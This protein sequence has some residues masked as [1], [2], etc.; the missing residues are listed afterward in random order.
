MGK[1]EPSYYL[2]YDQPNGL[3]C[4]VF[5]T[6]NKR[7]SVKDMIAAIDKQSEVLGYKL[8]TSDLWFWGKIDG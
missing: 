8:K 2:A 6:F 7:P 1:T 5:H 3:K 4:V